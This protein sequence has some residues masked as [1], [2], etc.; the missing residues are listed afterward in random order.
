MDFG[1]KL[2]GVLKKWYAFTDDIVDFCWE[3]R[4]ET[5]KLGCGYNIVILV[6]FDSEG[7]EFLPKRCVEYTATCIPFW[8]VNFC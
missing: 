2:V 7:L 5:E 4:E 1:R 8:T 6:N 3:F